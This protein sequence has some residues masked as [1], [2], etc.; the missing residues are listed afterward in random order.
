MNKAL[1]VLL[2]VTYAATTVPAQTSE[3]FASD[4][5]APQRL[6]FTP[7]GNLLVSEGGTADPNTGRVSIVDAR[8]NRRSLIEG[9]PSGAAHFTNPFGPTGMALDGRTLYLAVGEGDVMAGVPPNYGINLNGPSS[10]IF[11]SILRFQFS[12]DIDQI[13][14]PFRLQSDHHWGVLDG[15]EIYVDN[16]NGDR[17]AIQMLTGFRPLVRNVLGGAERVR[18]SDPYKIVL[19]ST[20]RYLY[21]ADA[22]AESISRVDT[23]TGKYVTLFRF[24]PTVRTSDA[25]TTYNDNVPTSLCWSGDRLL[26]GALTGSPFP[27]GTST[28]RAF[29]PATRQMT[30][31]AEGFTAVTDIDC[32]AADTSRRLVAAEFTLD[33][34]GA[35]PTGR[36]KIYDGTTSTVV[37]SG[38]APTGVAIEPGSG[39]IYVALLGGRILRVRGR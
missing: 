7:A 37:A 34:T 39:D 14:T 36:V 28:I 21:V 38:F 19:D 3:T 33:I 4:L 29:D 20:K 18:P 1:F 5:Q 13:Q 31:F 6:L 26:V 30:A 16:A 24:A 35:A 25:G 32:A 2:G 11:S 9:L 15:Y 12:R 27:V 8:G 22:S 10:P 17:A 23:T